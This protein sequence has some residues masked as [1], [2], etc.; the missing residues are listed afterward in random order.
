MLVLNRV[1]MHIRMRPDIMIL[2][3]NHQTLIFAL[4]RVPE[5]MV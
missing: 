3:M 1:N 4:P 5:F 2:G